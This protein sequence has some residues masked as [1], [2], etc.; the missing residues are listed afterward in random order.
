MKYIYS[1]NGHVLYILRIIK[2]DQEI[3]GTNFIKHLFL[4][5]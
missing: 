4:L 1:Y 3:N 2:R 5:P